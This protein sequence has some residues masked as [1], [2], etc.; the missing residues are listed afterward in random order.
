[1]LEILKSF[2]MKNLEDQ[3]FDAIPSDGDM[4]E[5]KKCKNCLRRIKLDYVIC[6]YCNRSDF[7]YG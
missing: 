1:M 4:P 2:L 5:S 7:F 6:P 3:N